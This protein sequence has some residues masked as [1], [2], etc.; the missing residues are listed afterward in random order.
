MESHKFICVREKVN[1][2]DYFFI[3]VTDLTSNRIKQSI[4]TDSSI[5]DPTS[6]VI[7][8]KSE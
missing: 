6:K 4:A 7:T 3:I 2:T 5:M 8:L 1:D